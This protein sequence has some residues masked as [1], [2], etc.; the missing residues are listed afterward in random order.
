[1]SDREFHRAVYEASSDLAPLAESATVRFERDQAVVDDP[2]SRMCWWMR[3]ENGDWQLD[4]CM[5]GPFY[6]VEPQVYAGTGGREY[7]IGIVVD[8]TFKDLHEVPLPEVAGDA[9]LDQSVGL[10]LHVSLDLDEVIVVKGCL[11]YTSP[12]PRDRG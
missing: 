3:Q 4:V 12:S 10:R 1:M 11:L 9:D 5:P 6:G 2:A 7:L 8:L